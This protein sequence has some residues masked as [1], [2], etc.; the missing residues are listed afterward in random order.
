MKNMKRKTSILLA[1]LI[2]FS[3]LP[4]LYLSSPVQVQ[5]ADPIATITKG[6]EKPIYYNNYKTLTNDVE[7][8]YKGQ[9]ITI[10]MMKDW[11]EANNSAIDH[12]LFIPAKS[13]VT[14]NMH[15]LVYNRNNA[16][17]GKDKYNG[18]LI[19]VDKGATLIVNGGTDEERN[20]H[21]YPNVAVYTNNSPSGDKA[22]GRET[23]NGGLLTGGCSCDGAGGIHARKDTT[24][25]LNDTTIAGCGQTRYGKG[26]G[27]WMWDDDSRLVL[28]NSR[29][30]GCYASS[31]GGGICIYD[32]DGITI[33]LNN[34]IVDNNYAGN[35]GGGIYTDGEKCH[36]MG[37]NG[38]E[39]RNNYCSDYGGGLCINDQDTS[40][41][42]LYIHHNK[43]DYGGGAYTND[44]NITLSNLIVKENRSNKDGGGIYINSKKDTISSCEI[45]GN[46]ADGNAGG[47]GVKKKIDTGFVVGGK[48][49]IRANSAK[50]M[51][52]NFHIS[53]DDSTRVNFNLIKGSEVHVSY[54]GISGNYAM[55]TEGKKNDT[56]KSP[57]CIQYL[58]PANGGFHFAY[59]SAPNMRKIFYVRDGKDS[60]ATG[61]PYQR[62][63]EPTNVIAT[64][65]NNASAVQGGAA[66]AGIVGKVGPGGDAGSEYDLIRAFSHHQSTAG[67][68]DDDDN[69]FYYSDA[70]FDADPKT[71]N[72][73]LATASLSMAFSGMYLRALEE[74][75]VNG[76]RYYNKHAGIR[77]FLADIG[78]PDENITINES[79]EKVPG[80]DTIGVT[81]ASKELVKSNGEKTGYILLPVVVR[82]GGYER[83]WGSNATLGKAA[84]SDRGK[85]ALGFSQAADQVYA[86]IEKYIVKYQLQDAIDEGRVKFWVTGYSRAGATANITSKRLV[87]NYACS[88]EPGKNN[89]VF[90]YT[91]EAPMGG[92]D[93]AETL[94]EKTKYYCIHNLVNAVDIVPLVA[95]K[96]M[97]FK[98]YGVDHYIPGTAACDPDDIFVNPEPVARGGANAPAY[99]TRYIDNGEAYIKEQRDNGNGTI[100]VSAEDKNKMLKQLKAIDSDLVLDDYFHPMTMS[101]VPSI[102][103]TETGEYNN[104]DVEEFVRDFIRYAMEGYF[105]NKN[106]H[107]S[108]A[109]KHRDYFADNIQP[110]LRDTLALVFSLSDDE[111]NS[112]I[113]RA[114]TFMDKM[115]TLSGT[116]SKLDIYTEIIGGQLP[117]AYG[118]PHE[119]ISGWSHTSETRRKSIIDF[120]WQKISETGAFDALDESDVSTLHENWP[121]LANFAFSLAEGDNAYRPDGTTASDSTRYGHGWAASDSSNKNMMLLGTFATYSSYILM[122]HYPEVNLA[123]ARAYDSYY[124]SEETEYRVTHIGYQVSA[125]S[126][127]AKD[128]KGE[129]IALTKGADAG[130]S[131]YGDQKI[132][133]D[134]PSI[135][136]EAIY[137]DLI[138]DTESKTLA[139]NL[140][141][142]GGVDLAPGTD[143]DTG[144]ALEKDYT[145]TC[146]AISYG[147]R[148]ERAVYKLHFNAKHN[149]I[150]TDGTTEEEYRYYAGN[151]VTLTPQIPENTFF[152]Y[153]SI[154]L[155]DA[156]GSKVCDCTDILLGDDQNTQNVS[157]TMPEEGAEVGYE[158]VPVGYS[159]IATWHVQE[160]ITKIEVIADNDAPD[161]NYSI[162]P[163]A[164]EDLAGLA[165]FVFTA[166]EGEGSEATSQQG[167][168][169]SWSHYPKDESEEDAIL[170]TDETDEE[171]NYVAPKADYD[172]VYIAT[173][174]I[175]ENTDKNVAFAPTGRLNA[176]VR[177]GEDRVKTITAA[178]DDSDGSVT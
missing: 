135:V 121:K 117:P 109:V 44:I 113:D 21:Q 78:C 170:V 159:L 128:T 70:F 171:G 82:G 48:T 59:H 174:H 118:G 88:D 175:P 142:R 124:D 31:Y 46:H 116:V 93:D 154:E 85:E 115:G 127:F 60:S 28:N 39:I 19:L 86:E 34:S 11:N 173:I 169:I 67:D 157:F 6:N 122:N 98:R 81:I 165:R 126:A 130:N 99:A 76:N 162:V 23:F 106:E 58:Y 146:Y 35:R 120:F 168:L 73:H 163:V 2:L 63:A 96:Q 61:T 80:I 24:V 42:G 139:R 105:P 7:G 54:S 37:R 140:C 141:Y 51:G 29:V 164:G 62:P 50:G 89:Q 125:P 150:V 68:Q 20:S 27:I 152:K 177:N 64:H 137:Y 110:A 15:G 47:V 33:E 75:D 17:K 16:W 52:N 148:S 22:T 77:Q 112:F 129:R 83:E 45:A 119:Y 10:D 123:W 133:L 151:I 91:C 8:K 153:W 107:W 138:D 160:K 57:N 40:V 132:L 95:P 12:R 97:G 43:A 13:K 56:V 145:L 69:I 108:Q 102:S 111:S 71:Y 87:E 92:T 18:E 178:R 53:G 167:T 66:Q 55:V 1:A 166:G 147:T 134:I 156:N 136:G 155:L 74:E 72:D 114:S 144:E 131:L 84:G 79:M 104:N 38:S 4:D 100:R 94:A 26:G 149:V 103:I 172:T 158:R 30:T 49:L 41:S 176:S 161:E 101:F 14:L 90:S 3:T 25:I 65:A 9:T 36:V 32:D 143:P 5:A